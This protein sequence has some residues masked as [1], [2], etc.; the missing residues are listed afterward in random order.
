MSESPLFRAEVAQAHSLQMYGAIRLR[1]AV[2][3]WVLFAVAALLA[4]GLLLFLY[5]GEAGK[6]VKI[7][8]I[9][10]PAGGSLSVQVNG[11]GILQKVLVSEGQH[12]KKSQALFEMRNEH[13]SGAGEMNALLRGQLQIR[14]QSLEMEK[15]NLQQSEMEKRQ[16]L[17]MRVQNLELE[18]QQWEKEMDLA[19]RRHDLVRQSV[20]RFEVLRQSGYVAQPQWQQ[21][22]EELLESEAKIAGLERSRSQLRANKQN[23]LA[24]ISQL[25][26]QL[27]ADLAQNE[28]SRAA[29][30]QEIIENGA[31]QA[32][33]VPAP[34]DGVIGSLAFRS[35][36]TVGSGQSLA[37][38]LPLEQG[39]E[40]MEVHLFAPSKAVG[41][42]TSGQ[43]VRIRMQAFPYQKYGFQQ[44]IISEVGSTPFTPAELPPHLAST[45]LALA[46]QSGV[47]QGEA[48]YRIKVRLTQ[49]GV[50]TAN[51]KVAL[52]P[53]MSL[54]AD[55]MQEKRKIWEW[56][57]EPLLA[58][59]RSQ[60]TE[61]R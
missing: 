20:E 12:V 11:A 51:G 47:S 31:R 32:W 54:D 43:A 58:L 39:K 17:Q 40:G 52:K 36:Q 14:A 50:Q 28:R 5:Y 41:F 25:Q 15:R 55:I 48:L 44:G 34:E 21:K 4:T 42:I 61:Y 37:T 49:A 18:M 60:M 24:E 45:V 6:K 2:S 1:Q 53:G 27:A 26:T 30:Q 16:A 56:M 57:F 38:L 13:Q 3:A 9:T 23:V 22:N 59:R 33:I 7:A 8:G 19:R 46:Q 29:L 10:V 35:G